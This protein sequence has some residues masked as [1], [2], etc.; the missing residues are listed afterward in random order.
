MKETLLV[1]VK[2]LLGIFSTKII[3]TRG[4]SRRKGNY[5]LVICS[6]LNRRKVP[7]L[8]NYQYL[9]ANLCDKLV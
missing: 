9:L 4:S 7:E 5:Q 8:F 6:P 2:C 1:L 3:C